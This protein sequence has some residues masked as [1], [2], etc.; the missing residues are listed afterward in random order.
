MAYSKHLK[1]RAVELSPGRSAGEILRVLRREFPNDDLPGDR[2]VRRWCKDRPA[3]HVTQEQ[4]VEGKQTAASSH[5]NWEVHNERLAGV[6]EKLL[7]NDL[8]RVMK[9]V[10]PTGDIEYHLFEGDSVSETLY[11]L[12]EDDLSGRFERNIISACHEYTEWF[13]WH[14][15]LPHLYA[16]WPE[17][18]KNEGL[19]ITAEEQ[20]Y[21]LIETLRLLAERRTFK[22]TCPVCE[23]W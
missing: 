20:P 12:T 17:E 11:R 7:D 1:Q 8:K 21:Q 18:L 23:D 16:E 14:C 10:N 13:L 2:Q 22:G 3:V 6:A 15:F 4:R 9:W 5:E 19:Y